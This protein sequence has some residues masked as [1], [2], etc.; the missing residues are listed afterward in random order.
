MYKII[1]SQD[2]TRAVIHFETHSVQ[3]TATNSSLN[4]LYLLETLGFIKLK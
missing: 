1:L 3:V 2:R 4:V